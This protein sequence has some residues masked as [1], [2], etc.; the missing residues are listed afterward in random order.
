M[1]EYVYTSC[2]VCL[3][4]HSVFSVDSDVSILILIPLIR[5]APG[6]LLVTPRGA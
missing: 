4:P 6:N 1:K 3:T 2:G 5:F